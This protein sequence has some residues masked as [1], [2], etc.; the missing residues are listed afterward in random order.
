MAATTTFC[1]FLLS[2]LICTGHAFDCYIC[3]GFTDM[4]C[5]S[6]F[7]PVEDF[8]KPCAAEECY[9]ITIKNPRLNV[10]ISHYNEVAV[11]TCGKMSW[12]KVAEPYNL[13]TFSSEWD[14]NEPVQITYNSVVTAS[15]FRDLCNF[16]P[17][18]KGSLV[19]YWFSVVFPVLLAYHRF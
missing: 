7:E 12:E 6:P 14:V 19:L 1:V 8:K 10:T 2:V 5:N 17:S 3:D 9:K 15:C 13:T 11:R 4:R 16:S 18:L